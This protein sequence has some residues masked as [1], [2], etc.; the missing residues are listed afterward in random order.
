MEDEKIVQMYWD[1][2]QRAIAECSRK[3]SN[4]CFCVAQNLLSNAEDSEECVNDT[5]LG[6][7]NSIP[8]H[9]PEVLKLF[10][11][12]ITRALAF[13]KYKK[14]TAKKRGEGQLPLVLNELKECIS[15]EGDP[16]EAFSAKE[17]A[18]S[19]K[20]F[21]STLSPREKGL[22]TDRY[23]FTESMEKTAA[24]NGV[25]VNHAYVILS[26]VRRNLR[27]HLI[28]EGFCYE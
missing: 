23:F 20:K 4:Y 6:A 27:K 26:R 24:D 28:R 19:I 13:N 25:S 10:L 5:F 3:Y 1:R 9:R 14:R 8:P 2:D 21:V 22:F 7:W 15:G 18:E 16:E 11:A 12:K 17:L